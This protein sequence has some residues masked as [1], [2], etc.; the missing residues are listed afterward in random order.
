MTADLPPEL[1]MPWHCFTWTQIGQQVEEALEQDGLP[2]TDGFLAKHLLGFIMTHLWRTS[3]MSSDDRLGFDDVALIRAFS[4]IGVDC[5]KK[6]TR[7][8]G[9][10]KGLLESSGI[11]VGTITQQDVIFRP[12]LRT[13]VYRQIF[14][15]AV[16]D[17]PAILLGI[18]RDILAIWLEIAPNNEK[19]STFN[20]ALNGVLPEL[21]NRNT[22]W[23]VPS[24]EDHTWRDVQLT[25]PLLDLLVVEDQEA[26]FVDFFRKALEDLKE[27][28][29][30]E[31]LR[32]RV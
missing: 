29:V 26:H 25:S 14:E 30:I 2:P 24:L 8:V 13:V 9:H 10:L 28:G 11:G 17:Y 32:E 15:K 3:D 23:H 19:K 20:A 21:Q 1:A 22:G 6:V 27:C 16:W 12:T 31:A 7:L 4:H 5:D 18:K